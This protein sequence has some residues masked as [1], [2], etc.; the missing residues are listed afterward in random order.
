ML[1]TL[2]YLIFLFLLF[3]FFTKMNLLSDAL[4]PLSGYLKL[5]EKLSVEKQKYSSSYNFG[6]YINSNRTVE[7]LVKEC[8][9]YWDGK[10][11]IANETQ[12]IH[13]AGMLNLV[14]EK[15]IKEL[16]W[17]PKWDFPETIK[18]TMDWY[19]KVYFDERSSLESSLEDLNDYLS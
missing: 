19:K 5:A 16:N 8:L 12:K 11:E 2:Q 14:I 1:K 9:K 3:G 13:E 17:Q 10:Y 7:E 18:K 4:E 6:P 15:A